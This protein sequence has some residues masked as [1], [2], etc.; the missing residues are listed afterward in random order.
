MF[1]KYPVINHIL[2]VG[3]PGT[4]K[5]VT[6]V[7]FCFDRQISKDAMIYSNL[8]LVMKHKV[9]SNIDDIINLH[10]D[11]W[12]PSTFYYHDIGNLFHSRN[13]KAKGN[14]VDARKSLVNNYRKRGINIIGTLHRENEIDIEIRRI[15]DVFVYPYVVNN[16]DADNME[17]DIVVLRWYNKPDQYEDGIKPYCI[18]YYDHPERYAVLYDTLQEAETLK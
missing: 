9:I 18:S 16:G 11:N 10:G 2:I 12:N 3:K 14:I 1:R 15:M 4:Y 8:N 17:D 6:A 5:D 7:K 13:F